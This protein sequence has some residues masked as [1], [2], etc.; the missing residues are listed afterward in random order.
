MAE[1]KVWVGSVG[2]FL[3]DDSDPYDDEDGDLA[4]KDYVGIATT[5][6][7]IAETAPSGPNEVLR[8][9]DNINGYGSAI[10]VTIA[11]GV[12]TIDEG[13]LFI[14]ITGE[15]DTTDELTEIARSDGEPF[16]DGVL[17]ILTG[18]TDLDYK[19]MLQSGPFLKMQ[20]KTIINS[21]YD[22]IG[23][24]HRGLGIWQELWKSSYSA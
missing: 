21:Q 17:L 12:L 20:Y 5:G 11:G 22:S 6:K 14:A 23:L 15:G 24:I 16:D 8:W 1:Q 2:P 7:M 10:D 19:I 4:G 9:Q 3:Y 13:N 18:K